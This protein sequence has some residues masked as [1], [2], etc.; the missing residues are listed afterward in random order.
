V[1]FGIA[2]R[3]ENS[4]RTGHLLRNSRGALG[5]WLVHL[6]RRPDLLRAGIGEVIG[7]AAAGE[8]RAVIGAV[9]P[10]SEVRRAHEQIASRQTQGKL[11]LDPK[12]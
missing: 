7:A 5:F 6:F 3:E 11:L 2:S 8:L 4:I 1:I 10:L 12:A 9:Y